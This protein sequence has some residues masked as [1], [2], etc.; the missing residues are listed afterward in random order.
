MI[1]Y[2]ARLDGIINRPKSWAQ[3]REA[4]EVLVWLTLE[5]IVLRDR[6][7]MEDDYVR[8][9]MTEYLSDY[10]GQDIVPLS[11][12]EELTE[13]AFLDHLSEMSDFILNDFTSHVC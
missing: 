2:E 3:S 9:K 10:T 8:S 11:G 6:P 12:L 7:F 1:D 5:S 13:D 4:L